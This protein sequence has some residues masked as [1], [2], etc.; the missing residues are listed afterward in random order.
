MLQ[1]PDAVRASLR[2]HRRIEL[3]AR[4]VVAEPMQQR[5]DVPGR[6][7]GVK[8]ALRRRAQIAEQQLPATRQLEQA[9]LDRLGQDGTMA[10]NEVVFGHEASPSERLQSRLQLIV[11]VPRLGVPGGNR[12]RTGELLRGRLELLKRLSM[13][14]PARVPPAQAHEGATLRVARAH[15]IWREAQDLAGGGN[16]PAERLNQGLV[17]G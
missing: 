8:D 4:D 7:A 2:R 3:D 11:K 1:H 15:A 12:Q 10:S 14:R 9:E 16:R 6:T 13:L 5:A 17:I